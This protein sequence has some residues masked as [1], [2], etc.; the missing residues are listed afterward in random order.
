MSNIEG[1]NSLSSLG[2]A[3]KL[4]KGKDWYLET[5]V[6]DDFG[7]VDILEILK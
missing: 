3:T 1:N 4:G 6:Y 7:A 2:S 5:P